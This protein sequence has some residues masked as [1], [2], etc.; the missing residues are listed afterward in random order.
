[1]CSS[2]SRATPTSATR[3]SSTCGAGGPAKPRYECAWAHDRDAEKAALE[4]FVD[5][6]VRAPRSSIPA[7]T[8]S[9]TRR[10]SCRSCGRCRSSTPRARQ[11]VDELL[12][13]EVLVDLYA[14]VRQGMQVGEESYSLKKLERHHGFVRLEK[15]VRE[16]GG[17][18]VAYET[19]LETGDDEL[20]EAIRAY[21]EEDCR[22]TLSLRDWLLGEMRP[23]AEA[24]FGVD[25]DDYARARARRGARRRRHG[26]PTSWR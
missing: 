23:Q 1:M 9:T 22:S 26:C 18:I 5:R 24:E 13:G 2:T 4:R 14:V 21:N 6:V 17:S 11:E 15:R 16:G 8:S 7:C 20:L 25:F 3:A 12:R 19:W 10:T